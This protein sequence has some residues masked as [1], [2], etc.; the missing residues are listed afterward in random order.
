MFKKVV[1]KNEKGEK[2]IRCF[3][4]CF[5]GEFL[6]KFNFDKKMLYV[7]LKG[8]RRFLY[9]IDEEKNLVYYLVKYRMFVEEVLFK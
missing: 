4:C 1:I 6:F 3:I 5:E 2:V 8:Y 7:Y 9:K